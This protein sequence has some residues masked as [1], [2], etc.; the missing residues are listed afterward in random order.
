MRAMYSH[1]LSKR[2][3]AAGISLEVSER[4]LFGRSAEIVQ[5]DI[6]RNRL[7]ERFRLY[8]GASENR[9]EVEGVDRHMHQLVL[10]VQEPVRRFETFVSKW[11]WRQ[12]HKP[13]NTVR[14]VK[15]GWFTENFTPEARR[16]FLA[17]MDE[18]HLFIARLPH[19]T[20]TVWGAHQALKSDLVTAA[21]RGAFEPTVRQGEWFFVSLKPREALE[22]EVAASGKL[23]RVRRSVGIAEVAGIRRN[24]RPHIASEVLVLGDRAYVRGDVKHPDHATVHLPSWRRALANA[25]LVESVPGVNFVD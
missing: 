13:P 7:G 14:T 5:I 16:H 24:G 20:S 8:P 4:P 10:F 15:N 17:G 23:S 3:A 6:A 12:S 18:Q 9:V 11:Q 2:F 19:G 1:N 22:V 25:E 21:E